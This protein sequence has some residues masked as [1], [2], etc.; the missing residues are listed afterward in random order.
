MQYQGVTFKNERVRLDGGEFRDCTFD[1]ALLEYAGGPLS[2]DGCSF[3]G[4]ISWRF[5]GDFGR[6]LAAIGR[7]YEAQPALGLRTV[8]DCM[9]PKRERPARPGAVLRKAA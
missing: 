1:G 6:G 8:V 7:L 9:F 5:D 4:A 2:L 3:T